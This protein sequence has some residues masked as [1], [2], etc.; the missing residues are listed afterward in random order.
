MLQVLRLAAEIGL[1]DLRA[2]H[3]AKDRRVGD[4]LGKA[5]AVCLTIDL[6]HQTM[7]GSS[8]TYGSHA[9]KRNAKR[10][11]D[12][13]GKMKRSEIMRA[14]KSRHTRPEM[15]VRRIAHGLGFRFRLHKSNLPGCPDLAFSRMK[16]AI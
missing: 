5:P 15:T 16:K 7:G 2:A 12:H 4:Q 3:T 13:V 10:V 9:K 14:V 6:N 11:V 8:P 1:L